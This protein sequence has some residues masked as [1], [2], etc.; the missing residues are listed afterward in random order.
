MSLAT[1]ARICSRPDSSAT[2]ARTTG[3]A[4]SAGTDSM[5]SICSMALRT[6][7]AAE[8]R[9]SAIPSSRVPMCWSMSVPYAA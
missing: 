1:A 2:L 3:G 8:V 9:P 5:R 6:G 7:T 4:T